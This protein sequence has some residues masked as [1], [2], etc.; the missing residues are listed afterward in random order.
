MR[1][2]ELLKLRQNRI[3][4]DKICNNR[5]NVVPFVGAGISVACL[6]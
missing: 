3:R 4:L 5:R 6:Y 2:S 1:L